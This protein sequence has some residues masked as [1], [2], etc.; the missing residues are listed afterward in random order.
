MALQWPGSCLTAFASR[1]G[2]RR[3]LEALR[4]HGWGLF[5]F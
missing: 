1:T 2:Y 3:T 5:V 4:S